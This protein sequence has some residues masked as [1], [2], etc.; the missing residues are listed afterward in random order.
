VA[1]RWTSVDEGGAPEA[2]DDHLFPADATEDSE[3]D[4]ITAVMDP[5]RRPDAAAPTSEPSPS[6]PASQPAAV[7]GRL[8]EIL[9]MAPPQDLPSPSA[10]ASEPLDLASFRPPI[11]ETLRRRASGR[12]ALAR[13]ESAD[14]RREGARQ[15]LRSESDGTEER[16]SIEMEALASDSDS[17]LPA[18]AFAALKHGDAA[19]LEELALEVRAD[20]HE[21]LANRLDALGQLV[22]GNVGEALRRL[23]DAKATSKSRGSR[24]QCRTALALGIGLA[25]AG[26]ENDALLEVLDGLAIAR[27]AGDPKGERA[28]ARFLANVAKTSGRGELA[29]AWQSIGG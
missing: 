6:P 15:T 5:G 25:V 28:C 4:E 7:G 27:A 12:G 18:R 26:R 14:T 17:L 2:H 24:E 11:R 8:D 19:T 20:S 9:P 3:L 21:T 23:R 13:S 29:K 1:G 16:T 22:K 10:P